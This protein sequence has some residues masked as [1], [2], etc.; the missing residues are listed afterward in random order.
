MTWLRHLLL[1]LLPSA[2][3][4][5]ADCDTAPTEAMRTVCHQLNNWDDSARAQPSAA[6]PPMGV[7]APGIAG[8]ASVM[9]ELPAATITDPAACNDIP[10]ICGIVG[11]TMNGRSCRLPSGAMYGKG[12]RKEYR[13]MTDGE[14]NRF[15]AAMWTLKNNG[16][17][18]RLA[19]I[20]ADVNQAPSAHSGPAFLAWHRE[21]IKRFE[22]ALRL[23]DPSLS[24][25]YWDTTLEGALADVKYSCL[26]STELMGDT[27]NGPVDTGAF[28]G[29]TNIDGG[30]IVR[31]LGQ[32]SQRVLNTNDRNQAL[33]KR[34]IEGIMA[35]TSPRQGCPF[36]LQWDC[37]EFA[38]GFSH[39]Y[40]GGEML[41]Q[42]TAAFDPIF[43]LYHS[44][45]DSLWEIW[46]TQRQS[47]SARETAYPVDNDACS[48]EAH[49]RNSIMSP[50][51]PLQ[52]IDGCSNV[53]TDNLYTYDRRKPSCILGENC[54]SRF[55]FCDRSNGAP[56]CAPKIRLDQ[57]C[58]AYDQGEDMCYNSVCI[59]GVCSIDPNSNPPQ[60]T[61]PPIITVPTQAPLTESCFNEHECCEPWQARG[62]CWQ[63]PSYMRLWCQASCNI[64]TPRGYDLNSECSDRHP[65]C[66][67]WAA[68][69]ECTNNSLW[70]RE[71]CRRS[72]NRCGRTRQQTCFPANRRVT[73]APVSFRRRW[74][75]R[76]QKKRLPFDRQHSAAR[77]KPQAHS[78]RS[79][80]KKVVHT[81]PV[82]PVKGPI[83]TGTYPERPPMNRTMNGAN[84]PT[85][86][87]KT[88]CLQLNNW[89]AVSRSQPAPAPAL[90]VA[91]PGIGGQAAVM[92]ILPATITDPAE[93]NDIPCICNL[94]GGK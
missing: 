28:R 64:C 37:M 74:N 27:M 12:V 66:R 29:W 48:S 47:R 63:N 68:G 30:T 16:D 15:H 61:Q 33:A 13:M 60:T 2:V 73:M 18:D 49:F 31:N 17:Y 38:H 40:V 19:H 59:D 4:A 5:Q 8:Q 14:R 94:V 82:P 20:H 65:S 50:F 52:N 80:S 44:Y 1:L 34:T 76:T 84:A 83:E 62:E 42:H 78:S 77:A 72:C 71:N 23:V 54:G 7:A 92:A 6:P 45:I 22:I 85:P 57:P 88:V 43:F 10:C 26:W 32:D 90:A 3:Y 55:L 69:G 25:P 91:A 51:A 53:Y 87:L 35:Y 46:R 9:M 56:H 70:M 41:T 21:F 58:D 67:G 93:C 81:K 36:P 24:L 79:S 89:D 11:G 39:V 75:L 86:A